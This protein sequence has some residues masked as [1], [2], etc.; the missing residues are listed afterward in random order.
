MYILA[1]LN[2]YLGIFV[3][4]NNYLFMAKTL[5]K[6]TYRFLFLLFY[7]QTHK[8]IYWSDNSAGE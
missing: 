5:S 4:Y 1:L 3:Y 6:K 7:S 8:Q 2:L